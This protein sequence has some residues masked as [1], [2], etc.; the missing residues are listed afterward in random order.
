MPDSADP[1]ALEIFVNLGCPP[2][3][4]QVEAKAAEVHLAEAAK[5]PVEGVVAEELG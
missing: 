3:L 2:T 1:L 4:A 5:D